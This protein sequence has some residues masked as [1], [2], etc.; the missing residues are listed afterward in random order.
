L[1]VGGIGNSL[2][3]SAA[4]YQVRHSQFIIL[5]D[6]TMPAAAMHHVS[7]RL[8]RR[9]APFFGF[10][11]RASDCGRRNDEPPLANDGHA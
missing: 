2:I 1:I 5:T 8:L 3:R 6:P 11:A 7:G 9:T 4:T 10:P